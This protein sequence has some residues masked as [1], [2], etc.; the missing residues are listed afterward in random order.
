MKNVELPIGLYVDGQYKHITEVVSGL[1][2]D[3]VCPECGKELYAVNKK[4]NKQQ[5][6]FRH[7]HDSACEKALETVLHKYAKQVIAEKRTLFTP[8]HIRKIKPISDINGIVHTIDPVLIPEQ[9]YE[10]DR[11]LVEKSSFDRKIPDLIG[12][13]DDSFLNIEVYV[14]HKVEE[15]KISV[16]RRNNALLI[17][18]DLSSLDKDSILDR[19][20]LHKIIIEDPS[21]KTWLSHPAGDEKHSC[22]KKNLIDKV[23]E[24]DKNILEKNGYSKGKYSEAIVAARKEL[25][26]AF[27][28]LHDYMK[29]DRLNIRRMH[30]DKNK[31]PNKVPFFCNYKLDHEWIFSWHRSL[32]QA[33]VYKEYIRGKS[34]EQTNPVD[35]NSIA[36]NLR[37]IYGP[38]SELDKLDNIRSDISAEANSLLKHLFTTEED[39]LLPSIY[40]MIFLYLDFLD[41]CGIVY[42]EGAGYFIKN[43]SYKQDV[44]VVSEKFHLSDIYRHYPNIYARN[45]DNIIVFD[46]DISVTRS[47][48]IIAS[49]KRALELSEGHGRICRG[50]SMISQKQDGATC[51]FCDSR[52]MNHQFIVNSGLITG[53]GSYAIQLDAMVKKSYIKNMKMR[54]LSIVQLWI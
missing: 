47:E 31:N 49:I 48:L 13:F 12:C 52:D 19:E 54:S 45:I 34:I 1:E 43:E 29:T 22:A 6:H 41:Q 3:C 46:L 36:K 16:F 26:H 23:F 10:F 50:C 8:K 2:C 15:E 17:E 51:P 38:I 35:I 27:H 14:R 37:L 9:R 5:K 25:S 18:I 20:K 7:A 28:T 21:N 30:L 32:W 53:Y 39:M 44:K 11:V 40:G 24:I 4:G 33:Y 42:K